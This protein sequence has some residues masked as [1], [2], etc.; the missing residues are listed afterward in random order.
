MAFRF[1]LDRHA[2]EAASLWPRR[3]HTAGAPDRT[4]D[5]LARLD[6]RVEAHL[7]AL[8]IA[9]A[10]GSKAVGAMDPSEPGV[11]FASAAQALDRR[12]ATGL[13]KL[14]DAAEK[15]RAIVAGLVGALEWVP[16]ARSE[17][18]VRAMLHERCPA[19]LRR[20]GL[21]AHVAQRSDPG[22]TLV[23]A[24]GAPAAPLR[25]SAL[26]G[27]A[28]LGRV[29]LLPDVMGD[30]E[31]QSTPVRLAARLAATL[32]GQAE[33]APLLWDQAQP[34]TPTGR[35]SLIAAIARSTVDDAARRIRRWREDASKRRD[36]IEALGVL[37]DP[38][39]MS[40]IL[41]DMRDPALARCAGQAFTRISGVAIAGDLA[42]P[43]PPE[44]DAGPND[45]P[46][47]ENVT[48][49][50]DGALPW[51]DAA[52]VER[53]WKAMSARLPPGARYLHGE[54]LDV[55]VCDRA[56]RSGSQALRGAVAIERALC[57]PGQVVAAVRG[58]GFRQEGASCR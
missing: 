18:A 15:D 55:D 14:L 52:A 23:D 49:D 11:P 5:D 12:D 53:A 22:L 16:L 33:V 39:R 47:D 17:W 19:P 13:A 41:E 50:P 29:E 24:M 37:G 6:L 46:A 8:R 10:A 26:E 1:V 48:P 34:T 30:V 45:D 27:A 3:E 4:L 20:F 28:L 31:A 43:P 42:A 25:A 9:G 32:L 2:E 35:A 7:D 38:A 58:P 36:A 56:L 54:R 57:C 21:A 51:P 44:G 40:W